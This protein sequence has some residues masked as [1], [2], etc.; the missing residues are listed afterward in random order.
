[1][2]ADKGVT[3][4]VKTPS[5]GHGGA[6]CLKR[7]IEGSHSEAV[8]AYALGSLQRV[9]SAL[10]DA[11]PAED[12]AALGRLLDTPSPHSVLRRDDLVVRTERALW[13]APRNK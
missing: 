3:P 4:G 13:A 5:G 6:I 10:A 1:V 7:T 2:L 9:R 11:L 8:G 12:L